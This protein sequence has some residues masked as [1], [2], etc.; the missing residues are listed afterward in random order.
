MAASLGIAVILLLCGAGVFFLSQASKKGITCC[1]R[2]YELP[3]GEALEVEMSHQADVSVVQA[4]QPN[5]DANNLPQA[6][7]V[8]VIGSPGAL[9]PSDQAI[10]QAEGR[11]ALSTTG[12]AAEE[13]SMFGA[14]VP[15][16][17]MLDFS[18]GSSEAGQQ[19]NSGGTFNMTL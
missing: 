7:N 13:Q 4:N 16:I 14:L 9:S 10:K 19:G 11:Y 3:Q 2:V 15:Q 1:T 8:Q 12:G 6:V 17:S 5:V 18:G